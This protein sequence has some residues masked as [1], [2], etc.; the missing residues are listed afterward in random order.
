MGSEYASAAVQIAAAFCFILGKTY[1]LVYLLTIKDK[2]YRIF[3][4][5]DIQK[6][7]WLL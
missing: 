4:K 6:E 1:H 2:K 5:I 7:K 3:V